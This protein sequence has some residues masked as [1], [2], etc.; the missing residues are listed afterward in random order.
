MD[1]V[2]NKEINIKVSFCASEVLVTEPDD[3]G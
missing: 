1:E 2:E 3:L